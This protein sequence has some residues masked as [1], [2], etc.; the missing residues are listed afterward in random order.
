MNILAKLVILI[1]YNVWCFSNNVYYCFFSKGRMQFQYD[2]GQTKKDF[3]EFI[4]NPN[5]KPKKEVEPE[6]KDTPSE[7]VHLNDDD[8]NDFIEVGG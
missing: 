6:W 5:E 1:F 8:F 4:K 2:G 7:V 3:I